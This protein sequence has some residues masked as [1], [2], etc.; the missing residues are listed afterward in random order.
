MTTVAILGAG[1]VG[2]A[3]AERL[4][5]AGAVVSFGVRDPD[6]TARGPSG[7][8]ANTPARLASDAVREARVVLLAVPAAAALGAVGSAGDMHGKI[9][10]DCTNPLRWEGGPVWTPP[11]EG[12][13]AQALA[14]AFPGARVVK[15]FNTFGAEVMRQPELASGAADA[16]FAGDDGEAKATI[17]D[18]ATG[19]GF[20]ANDAGPL[21][22]AAVLE[23][24]AMLWIHM[25]SVGGVGRNYGFR[26]ERQA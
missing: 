3:L 10:V 11:P 2:T 26:M 23:N 19:M 7:A 15:G 20:R 13:V 5:G 9:L 16:F 1:N 12:S 25:A 14:T 22:N 24:L 18:L 4:L 21:R 17:M 6:A 8:L